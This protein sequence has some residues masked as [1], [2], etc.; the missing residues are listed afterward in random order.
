MSLTQ[1]LVALLFESHRRRVDEGIALGDAL[2]CR[3]QKLFGV[4][5]AAS[6]RI[7]LLAKGPVLRMTHDGVGAWRRSMPRA[8]N[9]SRSMWSSTSS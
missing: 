7:G 2:E 9:F 8:G 1:H 6:N 3:L 5:V 4:Q